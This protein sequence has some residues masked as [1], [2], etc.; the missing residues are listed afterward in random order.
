MALTPTR[1]KRRS[2]RRGELV[3]EGYASEVS[4]F[5]AYAACRARLV[6]TQT[7]DGDAAT[8][9]AISRRVNAYT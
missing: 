6:Q 4:R 1:L 5:S 9:S 7:A 3:P 2:R 8:C